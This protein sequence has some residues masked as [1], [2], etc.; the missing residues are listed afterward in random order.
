MIDKQEKHLEFDLYILFQGL[1]MEEAFL[2]LQLERVLDKEL[3]K[4]K[5]NT[6]K[7][8]KRREETRK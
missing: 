5:F 1:I 2:N 7:K 4:K 3:K 8:E 6:R